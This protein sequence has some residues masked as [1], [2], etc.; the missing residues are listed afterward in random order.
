MDFCF[1][2]DNAKLKRAF[3][4]IVKKELEE[5]F[6][7][8]IVANTCQALEKH[9]KVQAGGREINLFYL[10]E[11]RET[12]LKKMVTSLLYMVSQ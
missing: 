4:G 10:S 3:T 12:G 7:H 2:P 6:S 1:D 8:K 5:Q 11:G 9:Y